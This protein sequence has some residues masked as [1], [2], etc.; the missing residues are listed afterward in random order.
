MML[1]CLCFGGRSCILCKRSCMKRLC[2][3]LFS[4]ADLIEA[5]NLVIESTLVTFGEL[6]AR[7]SSD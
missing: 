7:A 6:R 2:V 1:M 5:P 3:V 4:S